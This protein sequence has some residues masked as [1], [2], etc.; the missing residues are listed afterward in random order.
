MGDNQTSYPY[1]VGLLGFGLGV[2]LWYA[3]SMAGIFQAG[4][5]TPHQVVRELIE[6][7]PA[8][9]QSLLASLQ[10]V[11][12]GLVV[13]VGLAVPLGFLLAAN[14]FA[15]AAFTPVINFARALPP[16][17]LIP[18]VVMYFGIGEQARLTVLTYS[19][20]FPALVV[21]FE[22]VTS[23]DPVYM[24]AGQTLGAGRL[25]I[26]YRIVLP[27][28]VPAIFVAL[29]VSLGVTWATVVAA[30]LI[31]AQTGLGAFIQ[32]AANFF[33]IS[34]VIGGVILIGAAAVLMDRLIQWIQVHVLVWQ[35]RSF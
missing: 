26:F 30:E 24:R 1:Y 32:D 23:L 11:S 18:L 14:R 20:F 33:Q 31:A 9:L 5:P 17:A 3:L 2:V 22:S 29:R 7:G 10:R 21:I 35:E 27:A 25:E 34:A 8:A 4:L 16:I 6:R 15:S 28:T 19:A 13:G 12:I